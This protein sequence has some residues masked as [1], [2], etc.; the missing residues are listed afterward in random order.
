MSSLSYC[1]LDDAFNT[2][3]LKKKKKSKKAEYRLLERGAD[4]DI[5]R[6]GAMPANINNANTIP[7]TFEQ[8]D[9]YMKIQDENRQKA[10]D[11]IPNETHKDLN[12]K[13]IDFMNT[14]Q[15]QIANLTEQVNNIKTTQPV[16]SSQNVQPSQDVYEGYTNSNKKS[17]MRFDNDQFNELL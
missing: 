14:I 13:S 10:M 7:F 12:Q 3:S 1:T 11:K 5:D 6:P 8:N 16:Q 17:I 15:K 2:S 4:I 9:N